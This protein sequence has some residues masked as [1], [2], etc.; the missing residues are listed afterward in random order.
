MA[1]YRKG[2][3]ALAA[4]GAV[5]GTGT[6]W[7]S[8]LS[9]I[10]VGATVI[11]LSGSK[12]VIG[13]I[14]E[15]IS[16]TQMSV[17]NTDGG[18]A[19]DG[20]YT[21]L[22]N[23][24]LTVDG[25]A[26]DVAETLRYYQ[27]QE[28]AIA[29]IVDLIND[30]DL[31]DL[32]NQMNTI[33][34]AA[35]A[36]RDAAAQ[37]ETDAQKWA[38]NPENS[39]VEGGL[40]SSLH[41]SRKSAASAQASAGSATASENSNQ[42]SLGHAN[43]SAASAAA[44]EESNQ[45]SLGHANDSAQ[46]AA[47]ALASEG[48]INQALDGTIKFKGRPSAF[49]PAITHYDNMG[50]T[51]D[52]VGT[53]NVTS[54]SDYNIPGLPE[55]VRGQ[56]EVMQAGANSGMQKFLT[57][58]GVLYVRG[59]ISAWTAASPNVWAVWSP[60][61][62]GVNG[63][64]YSGD[65]NSLTA[66]GRYATTAEALNL[67]AGISVAGLVDVQ[68]RTPNPGTDF[69][70]IIQTFS[71][72]T[73]AAGQQA[74]MFR[75]VYNS[76]SG[77]W[78]DWREYVTMD[79][80]GI[81]KVLRGVDS[82]F[83]L[84]ADGANP[85]EA[86]TV[87]QMQQA[88]SAVSSASGIN[89]VMSTFIGDVSWWHGEPSKLPTAYSAPSGQ[90]LLRSDY[91]EVWSLISAGAFKSVTDALWNSNVVNRGMFSTGT[92][93]TGANANFRMPDY[94]GAVSGTPSGV[95][96]RGAQSGMLP[97]EMRSSAIPNFKGEASI[98]L[99]GVA[100]IGV[101]LSSGGVLADRSAVTNLMQNASG[102]QAAGSGN[103]GFKID[104]SR[105]SAV[106]QDGVTE[107]RPSSVSGTWIMRMKGNFS[108]QTSFAVMISVASAPG[109]GTT[110]EGG[111]VRSSLNGP[112]GELGGVNLK[113]RHA[114]DS[115]GV[116]TKSG[117]LGVTGG[118]GE[119]SVGSDG[120]ISSTSTIKAAGEIS[121]TSGITAS[122][123]ELVGPTPFIDFHFGSSSDDYTFRL[124]NQ[125]TANTLYMS[126][127]TAGA[128]RLRVDGGYQCKGGINGGFNNNCFNYYWNT[129]SQV[130]VWIDSSQVGN[131]SLTAVSDKMLK[132]DAKYADLSEYDSAYAEVKSW[133]V[134][135]FKY[136]ARGILPES[137]EKLGFIAND[138]AI[139]SPET[140]TGD[141]LPEDFDIEK[142]PNDVQDAY[143]L[144]QVAMIA[145]LTMAVQSLMG[146]VEDL[147]DEIK[148]LKGE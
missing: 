23:D 65:L 132:T 85:T 136:K 61:S 103:T 78:Y 28:T 127:K 72:F 118:N 25:L 141:G 31:V 33:K 99:S 19:A 16:D 146:K 18:T 101:Q 6:D 30:T 130:E 82:S 9:L 135:R 113:Y 59:L 1:I 134:A 54:A 57:Q 49:T 98:N 119:V 108:A 114:V 68:S 90:L 144:D 121:T 143:N 92:V 126:A 120:S 66:Q 58:Y 89:G 20:V 87:R 137:S 116:V 56:L 111:A 45:A 147:Q 125:A 133:K 75:R 109:N 145:K 51:S 102:I 88:I 13:S 79:L 117:V 142:T 7:K 97:G 41:Y 32:I 76:T 67:P 24:G 86:V 84:G 81:T 44:S 148:S 43:D 40:Y 138:L 26:Q 131:M 5:T 110:T 37:S 70:A 55:T 12:P 140:V 124:I 106:Y 14:A 95:F 35:E 29:D 64:F 122:K 8:P 52:F 34:A 53:W 83:I 128:A 11:F 21:I 50:P 80:N 73:I 4:N 48:R 39:E 15:I 104:G 22:L 10:R 17:I 129:G 3:A 71:I 94:N 60:M 139:T 93:T 77:T 38:A 74:R 2:T 42:A 96:M 69:G 107:V 123:M 27:S 46:S 62:H 36:A 91:P 105:A 100:N 112:S 47:N 63:N 115:S